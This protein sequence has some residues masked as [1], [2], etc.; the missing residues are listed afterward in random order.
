MR[1]SLTLAAAVAAAVLGATPAAAETYTLL[2]Y[3]SPAELKLRGDTGTAGAEYWG[4][5]AAFSQ[6]LAEA[7]VMRGGAALT[8][9]AKVTGVT[10]GGYFTLETATRAEAERLAAAAPA[11]KRGGRVELRANVPTM[12]PMR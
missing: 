6:S 9:P 2:I 7:G 3:E 10:L 5:Y 4:S 1:T 11:A 12:A 8:V